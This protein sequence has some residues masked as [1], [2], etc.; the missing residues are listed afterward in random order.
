MD[1]TD[2]V[3]QKTSNQRQTAHATKL[4]S[5]TAMAPTHACLTA[6]VLQHLRQAP[7]ARSNAT[8][9]HTQGR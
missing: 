2:E 4:Y 3:P 1:A 9:Q 7:A 5:T 6:R 8:G